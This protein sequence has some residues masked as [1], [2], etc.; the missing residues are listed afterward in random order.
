MSRFGSLA[1]LLFAVQALAQSG[2]LIIT[3]TVHDQSGANVPNAVVT[4]SAVAP[5]GRNSE[6]R[7]AHTGIDGAFSFDKVTAGTYNVQVLQEGFKIA[8]ARVTVGNRA[9]RPVDIKLE[10]ASLEQQITV[11]SELNQISTQTDDNRDV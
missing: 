4:L 5:T 3:G 11:A 10:I 2:S 1:L 7:T 8:I 6:T 9:P